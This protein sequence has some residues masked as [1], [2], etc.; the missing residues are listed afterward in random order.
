MPEGKLPQ[1]WHFDLMTGN[2]AE[3]IRWAN[4]TPQVM[5]HAIVQVVAASA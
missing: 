5:P 1:V 2:L 3:A 4:A